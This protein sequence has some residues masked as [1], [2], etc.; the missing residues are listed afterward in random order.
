MISEHEVH[1]DDALHT[2]LEEEVERAGPVN[3]EWLAG[4]AR[5]RQKDARIDADAVADVVHASTLLVWRPDGTVDHL[6]RVLDGIVLTQRARAPL[7]DRCDLWATFALQP[8]LNLA[9]YRPLRLV[10]GGEVRRPP[11]GDEVLIGPPGWLPAV[12][13]YGLVGLRLSNGLLS[14]SL[15]QPDSLPDLARQQQVRALIAERYRRERWWR[16]ED[17]LE[18]RPAELVRALTL[19]R[20]EDPRLLADPYPPLDELLYDPLDRRGDEHHFRD[21]AATRQ[22]ESVGFCVTGMPPALHQELRHR[23]GQFGMSLDQY[24]VAVLGHL[25][26]RTPF[27]EDLEPWDVYNPHSREKPNLKPLPTLPPDDTA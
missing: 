14:T 17:D 12:D 7:A 23:A 15:V 8:L 16:G 20:M 1:V 5:R 4:R 22:E 13:R 10:G 2:V 3:L 27:A 25:A 6:S 21:F 11:S 18:S 19:A 24:V 26:W 9:V